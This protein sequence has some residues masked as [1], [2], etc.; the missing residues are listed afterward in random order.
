MDWDLWF[1]SPGL[2][3][4]CTLDTL[5]TSLSDSAVKRA[6]WWSTDYSKASSSGAAVDTADFNGWNTAQKVLF[7]EELMGHATR[8]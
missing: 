6:L 7:I 3:P 2:P 5:D 4:V 1:Y 8:Y